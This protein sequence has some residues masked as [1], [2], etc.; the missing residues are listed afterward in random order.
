MENLNKAS[1]QRLDV[2]ND[3]ILAAMSLLEDLDTIFQH[4][5]NPQSSGLYTDLTA[6]QHRLMASYQALQTRLAVLD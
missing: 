6:H 1:T 4:Q 3:K 2:I 5:E